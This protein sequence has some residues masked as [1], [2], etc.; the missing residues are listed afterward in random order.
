MDVHFVNIQ[1]LLRYIQ[2]GKYI[3]DNVSYLIG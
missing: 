2:G 3:L 1:L